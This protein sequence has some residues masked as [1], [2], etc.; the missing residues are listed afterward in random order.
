MMMMAMPS[1]Q[2][3]NERGAKKP[4]MMTVVVVWTALHARHHHDMAVVTRLPR[5][6]MCKLSE[7]LCV[8]V[9]R[10]EKVALSILLNKKLRCRKK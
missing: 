7:E 6:A 2:E 1:R 9:K 3:R 8:R 5:F 4:I 10:A